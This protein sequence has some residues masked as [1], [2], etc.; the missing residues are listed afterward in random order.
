VVLTEAKRAIEMMRWFFMSIIVPVFH[1]QAVHPGLHSEA[2][3]T[4]LDY[5]AVKPQIARRNITS[6]HRG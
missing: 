1:Q 6:P 2:L 3:S 4:V 5:F